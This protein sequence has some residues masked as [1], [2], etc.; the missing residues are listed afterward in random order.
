MEPLGV[1]FIKRCQR[2][3]FPLLFVDQIIDYVPGES[4]V[5]LKNFTY[6]EWFFPAHFDDEPVVPGFVQVEMLA[7]TFIMTFLTLDKHMGEKTAFLSIDQVRFHRQLSPGN[8]VLVY[9]KL[10]SFRFGIAE[11]SAVAR[12]GGEI[13]VEAKL[14]VAVRSILEKMIPK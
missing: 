1:E 7:Q 8:Q 11:G 2:N 14:R 6:G 3:R 4:A 10:D 9:A 13:V 12:L 5:A